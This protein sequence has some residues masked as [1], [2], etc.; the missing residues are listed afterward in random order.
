MKNAYLP[1]VIEM[2]IYIESI[3]GKLGPLSMVK[4][5]FSE[6]S[7]WLRSLFWWD[8]SPQMPKGTRNYSF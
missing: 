7:Y 1:S 3:S 4:W 2:L 5:S 6:R 8:L